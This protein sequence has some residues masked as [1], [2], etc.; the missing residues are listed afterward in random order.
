MNSKEYADYKREIESADIF[1]TIE[2]EYGEYKMMVNAFNQYIYN[3]QNTELSK[4]GIVIKEVRNCIYTVV[5]NGFGNYMA[6]GN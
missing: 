6:R 5:N 3:A 1:P 2:L 4:R